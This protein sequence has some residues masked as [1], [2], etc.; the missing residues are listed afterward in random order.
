M[1]FI[2]VQKKDAHGRDLARVRLHFRDYWATETASA[3]RV[4]L[5][6]TLSGKCYACHGSGMRLLIPRRGS[7]AASAPVRGEEGYGQGDGGPDFGLYRLASLNQRLISY[8]MPDWNGTIE[9]ADHGPPLGQKLGCSGCHNGAVRGV[10]TVSTSEGMLGQ[11]IVEQLSM[12]STRDGNVIPDERAMTLLER[13]RTGN[14]PLSSAERI[15]LERARA[16]HVAD[17]QHFVAERFPAWR[18]WLLDQRCE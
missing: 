17:Y 16:D 9:P 7:V 12:R 11:K 1:S 8:G 10:L 18:A 15:E 14:P 5:P 6:E 13:D 3:W 2:G 4:S